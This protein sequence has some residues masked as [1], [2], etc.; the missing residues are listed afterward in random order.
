MEMC[1]FLSGITV[2]AT[3][4]TPDRHLVIEG[5]DAKI[6]VQPGDRLYVPV[7]RIELVR[8]STLTIET[9]HGPQPLI[10]VVNHFLR[11][12]ANEVFVVVMLDAQLHLIGISTVSRGDICACL[13]TPRL[14][15]TPALRHNAASIVIAHNHPSGVCDPS[16]EDVDV[17]QRI[18][19]CAHMMGIPLL[20]SLI[21][22]GVDGGYSF[23]TRLPDALQPKSI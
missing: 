1:N 14:V 9:F 22:D 21:V 8:E 15:F 16:S 18:A 7:Y 20:D 5:D 3:S 12:E 19:N 11:R 23:A 13:V 6:P 10:N 2:P 17:T 4:Q